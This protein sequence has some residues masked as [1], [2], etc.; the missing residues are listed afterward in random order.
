MAARV[1]GAFPADCHKTQAVP[2]GHQGRPYGG[3]EGAAGQTAISNHHT[4]LERPLR[5]TD[6]QCA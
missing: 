1:H 2:G 6:A 4:L 3:D 5:G